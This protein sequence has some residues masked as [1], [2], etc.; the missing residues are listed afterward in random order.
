[1]CV[2]CM[3]APATLAVGANLNAKQ[4][5]ERHDAEKRGEISSK[6]KKCPVRKISFIVAGVLMIAAAVYHSQLNG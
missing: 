4:L 3:A 5:S 6:K 2:F 1:M